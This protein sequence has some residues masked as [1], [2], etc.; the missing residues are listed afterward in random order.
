[1]FCPG[2]MFDVACARV[3]REY[4]AAELPMETFG[5]KYAKYLGEAY[6]EVTVD[7]LTSCATSILEFLS[8]IEAGDMSVEL[9]DHYC[10]DRLY[11]EKVGVPRRMKSMFGNVED[12]AKTREYSQELMQKSFR[13][14]VFRLRNDPT[15]MS[16]PGWLLEED[17]NIPKFAELVGEEVSF[18]D[19]L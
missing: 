18:L 8:E 11:F 5:N 13:T 15:I 3:A 9:I 19:T 1:M 6:S 17:I 16:P 4:L 2:W 7:Q 12:A 14:F 10:H